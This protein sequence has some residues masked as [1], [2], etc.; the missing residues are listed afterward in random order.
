M[1]DRLTDEQ[2][3]RIEAGKDWL[4]Q[5]ERQSMAAELLAARARITELEADTIDR[6]FGIQAMS[7]APGE[8]TLTTKP[9]TERARQLVLAMSLACGRMLDEDQAPNYVEFEVSP[10]GQAGYVVHVR[11][12]EGRSP[13]TLRRDAEARAERAEARIAELEAEAQADERAIEE[14][15]DERDAARDRAAELEAA[16]ARE[17][18]GY[19]VVSTAGQDDYLCLASD[20]LHRRPETASGELVMAQAGSPSAQWRVVELREVADRA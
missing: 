16:P 4:S 18:I 3:R 5:S 19:A 1:P 10:A 8:S 7:I 14:A 15:R 12:A 17:L 6:D 9:T 11:R 13:H 2:L 20:L